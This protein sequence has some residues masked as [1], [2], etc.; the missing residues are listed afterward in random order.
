MSPPPPTPR[1]PGPT[2]PDLMELDPVPQ[3]LARLRADLSATF[4]P[5]QPMRLAR[6]P[7]RLDAMGGILDYTGGLVCATTIDRAASVA[8]QDRDDRVVQVFSFN[9]M[10]AHKPFTLIVPL[11]VLATMPLAT[12]R[13]ALSEPGRQ[14]A[15]DIVGC[16]AILQDEGL[17]DLKDACIVGYNFALLST[18]PEGA[19]V[20]SSA[21]MQV[22]AMHAIVDHLGLRERVDAAKLAAMC[23]RVEQEVV[24]A[25]CG[26]ADHFAC[27]AGEIGQ[28]TR[29]LCQPCEPQA[30]LALPD[31]IRVVGIG[32]GV[33]RPD[34]AAFARTRCAA[35]MG[36]RIIFEKMKQ[37]GHAAGRELVADPMRGHLANLALD[38][39]K[40]FFRGFIPEFLKGGQFLL[41]YG[42]TIDKALKLEPDHNYPVQHATDHHVFDAN[43]V[44][45]FVQFLQAA[46]AA[47]PGSDERRKEL[48]KAGHLMYASHAS[49]TDD[50]MLGAPECDLLMTLARQ[51]EHEG[52]YGARLSGAGQGGTVVILA[53]TTDRADRAIAEIART[54]HQQ[55]GHQPTVYLHASPGAWSAGTRLVTA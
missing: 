13:E 36:Q 1:P 32:S 21:A 38:D 8:L 17:I 26:A 16:F 30:P 23:R 54:Y 47:A 53:D 3:L 55:T 52:L 51:R 50:A 5:G 4:I 22:A 46:R 20:A 29:V 45:N 43:R 35:F 18:V 9:L 15:G 49:M 6:A 48:N 14:W 27:G 19:G 12:L 37:L 24:G 41:Q 33:A 31:G 25:A 40:R 7:G 39:Y 10:D 2:S 42:S 11:D 28:L 34:D 44:R